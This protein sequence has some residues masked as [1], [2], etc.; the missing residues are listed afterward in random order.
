MQEQS[1]IT[2][3][4]NLGVHG[5]G[6]L[7]LTGE[8]DTIRGQQ[9]FLSLF[10]VIYVG[11]GS[12]LKSPLD[13]EPRSDL[14]PELYCES[15]TFPDDP[16]YP[17]E[18]CNVNAS[19]PFT[20]QI[21]RV[22]DIIIDGLVKGSILHVHRART[23]IVRPNGSITASELGID[24]LAWK[25]SSTQAIQRALGNACLQKSLFKICII[26]LFLY[27]SIKCERCLYF[28][29]LVMRSYRYAMTCKNKEIVTLY[30]TFVNADIEMV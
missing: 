1:V 25:N 11:V 10:Y 16:I 13:E 12:T 21:C 24:C 18:D 14:T 27:G 17:P 19:L 26:M 8:G 2:S 28:L 22:E 5:Q 3:N 15:E 29:F 23:V 7:N 30:Y 20:L 9:L 4:A 6:Q